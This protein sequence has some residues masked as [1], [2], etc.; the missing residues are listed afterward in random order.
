[1]AVG[2]ESGWCSLQERTES[3][4]G[5]A[6]GPILTTTPGSFKDNRKQDTPNQ[7]AWPVLLSAYRRR[8]QSWEKIFARYTWYGSFPMTSLAPKIF[9]SF[10]RP[11]VSPCFCLGSLRMPWAWDHSWLIIDGGLAL[12]LVSLDLM[13]SEGIDGAISP[14]SYTTD[15]NQIAPLQRKHNYTQ[16][17][18]R[19]D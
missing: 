7:L 2:D 17:T 18:R 6:T 5:C 15:R 3:S 14:S 4:A 11:I 19:K 13:E 9:S 12:I 1:M 8:S 16:A 10:V